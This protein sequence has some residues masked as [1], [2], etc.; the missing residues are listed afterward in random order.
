MKFIKDKK[1]KRAGHVKRYVW[2]KGV[3]YYVLIW[4]SVCCFSSENVSSGILKEICRDMGH[5]KFCWFSYPKTTRRLAS[6]VL[7][8]FVTANCIFHLKNRISAVP[9]FFFYHYYYFKCPAQCGSML[10]SNRTTIY[11][12]TLIEKQ[13]YI[14]IFVN[15]N[16]WQ[17]LNWPVV[18]WRLK[19]KFPILLLV[20]ILSEY[21][22]SMYLSSIY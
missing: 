22:L 4:A 5:I 12:L 21:I 8:F 6:E 19:C 7:V 10:K 3:L 2:L 11:L 15:F 16:L 18:F 13:P 9:F 20:Y 14:C 17:V 1:R